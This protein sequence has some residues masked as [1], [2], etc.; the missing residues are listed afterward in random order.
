MGEHSIPSP[1]ARQTYSAIG[2]TIQFAGLSKPSLQSDQWLILSSDWVDGHRNNESI[3]QS[4]SARGLKKAIVA[5]AWKIAVIMTRIWR[6][7]TT[8]AGITE[9]PLL[10]DNHVTNTLLGVYRRLIGVYRRLIG[11]VVR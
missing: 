1:N 11:T 8:F 9:K 7:G 2:A 4:S 6:D 10:R 5:K 3:D